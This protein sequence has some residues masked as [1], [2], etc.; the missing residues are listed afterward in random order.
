MVTA[1]QNIE[2]QQILKG[3]GLH[4]CWARM[5]DLLERHAEKL[6]AAVEAATEESYQ[7]VRYELQKPKPPLAGSS[8]ISKI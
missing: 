2:Y 7:F 5:P 6:A 3:G 4:W 8:E 1:D